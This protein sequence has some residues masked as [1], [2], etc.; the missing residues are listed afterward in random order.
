MWTDLEK[1]IVGGRYELQAHLATGGMATVFRGWD[2]RLERPVAIKMLRLLDAAEP[3]DVKRF[4]REAQATAI[5]HS[6]NIVEVYDFFEDQGCYYLVME[7]VDGVN[8]KQHITEHGPLAPREACEIAVQVCQGLAA[9]HD[10]GFIHRDTK[11]Q[12]ILL[13]ADGSVKLADF[14]IVRIPSAPAFTTSGIVLGTADYISP[15]QA[16]GLPLRPTTDLYSLGVVLYE[17]LTGALPFTGTTSVAVALRHASDPVVPPRRLNPHI[18]PAVERVVLRA[19]RKDPAT[20]YPTARAMAADLRRAL[21]T[22]PPHPGTGAPLSTPGDEVI[23]AAPASCGGSE[24][25]Q[26]AEALMRP[27]HEDGPIAK[28][29]LVGEDDADCDANYVASSRGERP[30][31]GS[32]GMPI[33]PQQDATRRLV[34][35]GTLATLLLVGILLLHLIV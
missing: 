12:N 27:T 26:L 2:H 31:S 14:G 29:M 30:G 11:P 25:H 5:L 34:T 15:E 4:R 35:A 8:L 19:M 21:E 22:C 1:A 13:G 18:P 7:L 28:Q 32:P 20:R 9:A 24:W 23:Y 6:P 33:A 16:Q 10:A 3:V 17:A